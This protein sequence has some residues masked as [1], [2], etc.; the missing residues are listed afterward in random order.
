MHIDII[1]LLFV[2]LVIFFSMK[3]GFFMEI[4]QIA[5]LVIAYFSAKQ[6]YAFTANTLLSTMENNRIKL[7][8]S[9]GITFIVTFIVSLLIFSAVKNAIGSDSGVKTVD[10]T[11][12]AFWGV[13]KSLVILEIIVLILIRL[14]ITDAAAIRDSSIT[15]RLL[16]TVSEYAGIMKVK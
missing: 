11:M 15:G 1:V 13:L 6:F 10:R 2:G 4:F 16:V 8:I 7:F 9:Y 3:K 5:S 12:G 14:E